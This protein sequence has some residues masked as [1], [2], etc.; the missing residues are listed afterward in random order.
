MAMLRLM[1]DIAAPFLGIKTLLIVV[2]PQADI[3]H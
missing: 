2:F 1:S 3:D